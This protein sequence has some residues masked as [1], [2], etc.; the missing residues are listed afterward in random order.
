MYNVVYIYRVV[1]L[2]VG[3]I[4]REMVFFFFVFFFFWGGGGGGG[5]IFF[6]L[7]SAKLRVSCPV[8]FTH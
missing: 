4:A 1:T 3:Y 6:V 8:H 2:V 5:V 7:E